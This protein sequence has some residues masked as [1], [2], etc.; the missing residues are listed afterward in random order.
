MLQASGPVA[1]R[2]K[3]SFNMQNKFSKTPDHFY[4]ERLRAP[5][6][7]S[8]TC[9]PTGKTYVGSAVN[10]SLRWRGHFRHLQGGTHHCSYLQRAWNKYG[11]SA[12][13]FSVLELAPLES[14]RTREQLH[15]D[16]VSE[17]R[18]FNSSPTA[19]SLLGFKMSPASLETMRVA[20]TG[21]RHSEETKARARIARAGIC[22]RPAGWKQSEEAKQ[23]L[24]AAKK[25]KPLSLEHRA[26][27]AATLIKAKAL[28]WTGQKKLENAD[29]KR[30]LANNQVILARTR[31]LAGDS[32]PTIAA[33]LKFGDRKTIGRAIRGVGIYGTIGTPVKGL[34]SRSPSEETR[35]RQSAATKG[36]P[37]SIETRARMKS[38]WEIRKA[39]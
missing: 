31:Y 34:I 38:A 20:H 10:M 13:L 29:R 12:F 25:G 22:P 35:Q 17:D 5:G 1:R 4:E 18:R 9:L 11:A 23:K 28:R 8:I 16:S 36:R 30:A 39:K 33:V 27:S 2:K 24:S 19:G 21:F 7:Y 32:M 26:K 37:K 14:L 3:R 15:I 6:I